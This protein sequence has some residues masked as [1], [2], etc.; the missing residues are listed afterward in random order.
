MC[1][2]KVYINNAADV[3]RILEASGKVLAV[4]QG[5]HHAGGYNNIAGIHYYTLKALI[6]GTGAENNAYAITEIQ[7]GG[8][9]VVT[10]Y[11]KAESRQLISPS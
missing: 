7:P 2:R 9:I 1:F 5:H 10:G 11:R 3:R 6:E 4:F 8:D